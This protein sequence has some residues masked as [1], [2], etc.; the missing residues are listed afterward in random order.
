MGMVSLRR[1]IRNNT[2]KSAVMLGQR[3]PLAAYVATAV[4][5]LFSLSLVSRAQFGRI[6]EES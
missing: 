5:L 4:L 3:L 2:A 6:V 1:L